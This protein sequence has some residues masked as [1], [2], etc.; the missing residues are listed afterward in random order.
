VKKATVTALVN[1]KGVY[2]VRRDDGSV[3]AISIN[4]ALQEALRGNEENC[5]VDWVGFPADFVP[6]SSADLEIESG[7]EIEF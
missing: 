7:R 5:Q 3:Y 4:A 2:L 6:P 1:P